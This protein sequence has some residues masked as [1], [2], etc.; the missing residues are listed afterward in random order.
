M[1]RKTPDETEPKTSPVHERLTAV[2]ALWTDPAIGAPKPPR[3]GEAAAGKSSA[4]H[5]AMP[6]APSTTAAF[7]AESSPA[8][9]QPSAGAGATEPAGRPGAETPVKPLRVA[10][11]QGI[12]RPAD[13]APPKPLRAATEGIER[14]AGALQPGPAPPAAAQQIVRPVSESPSGEADAVRPIGARGAPSPTAPPAQSTPGRNEPESA[15]AP[16][17]A[18]LTK[19]VAPAPATIPRISPAPSNPERARRAD[20]ASSPRPIHITIGRIE[21]RA[22]HPPPEPVRHRPAPA[23]PKISL[24]E[25]LKQRNGG[26]R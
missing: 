15:T 25:Y 13:G 3:Q 20:S 4:G 22:V 19:V 14:P 18:R 16:G 7:S 21:V 9:Q 17:P 24:E 23:A 5:A 11:T 10:A 26:R 6:I 1:P 2:D 12:E 8:Q